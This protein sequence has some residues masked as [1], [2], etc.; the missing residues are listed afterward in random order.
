MENFPEPSEHKFLQDI[1]DFF[2]DRA[3]RV[4]EA[5]LCPRCGSNMQCLDATFWVPET[6]L[7]W[8]F[9]IVT[10]SCESTSQEQP[11]AATR[12]N[13]PPSALGKDVKLTWQKL[14]SQ[15]ILETDDTVLPRRI[16]AVYKAIAERLQE[17]TRLPEGIMECRAMADAISTLSALAREYSTRKRLV[18][19][20]A[21]RA[22]DEHKKSA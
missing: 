9:P 21:P 3:A 2:D 22:A 8:S 4:V 20:F 6:D 17:V 1:K 12:K 18:P 16:D 13:A 14:F 11:Q 7:R 10:C 15:A 5:Q 19:R